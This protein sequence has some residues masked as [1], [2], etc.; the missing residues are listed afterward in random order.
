[1]T[2]R[3][4]EIEKLSARLSP[5]IRSWVDNVIVPALLKD[6]LAREERANPVAG[7]STG[8][9]QFQPHKKPSAEVVA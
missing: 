3:Q 6:W 7:S 2:D 8:V 1:V 5:S 9:T 4:K